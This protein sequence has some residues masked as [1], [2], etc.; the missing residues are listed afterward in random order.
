MSEHIQTKPSNVPGGYIWVPT[1]SSNPPSPKVQKW[2]IIIVCSLLLIGA[3]ITV[4]EPEFV[5]S[6]LNSIA[7]FVVDWVDKVTRDGLLSIHSSV[8][9]EIFNA[10]GR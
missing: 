1:T 8:T 4:M 10:W 3:T 7:T 2:S 6:I 5:L 9:K